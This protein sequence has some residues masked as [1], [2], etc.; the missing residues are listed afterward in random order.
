MLLRS[1]F[2]CLMR[3]NRSL[4]M[5][6]IWGRT[7]PAAFDNGSWVVCNQY[8]ITQL[9]QACSA[10]CR[11]CQY[12]VQE[13]AELIFQLPA[14]WRDHHLSGCSARRSADRR[15][16]GTAR[17]CL[18]APGRREV[19]NEALLPARSSFRFE[20]SSV[21]IEKKKRKFH[22]FHLAFVPRNMSLTNTP[23]YGFP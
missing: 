5:D 10:V 3:E 2:K 9:L 20:R 15:G 1:P 6:L 23:H 19:R 13:G 14:L 21:S 22:A 18:G 12:P 16:P 17:L 8:V 4:S 11:V 7:M